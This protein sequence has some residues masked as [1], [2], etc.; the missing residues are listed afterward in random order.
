MLHFQFIFCFW[1]SRKPIPIVMAL[2]LNTTI[3]YNTLRDDNR[4]LKT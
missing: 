2:C 1:I 3:N 4:Q